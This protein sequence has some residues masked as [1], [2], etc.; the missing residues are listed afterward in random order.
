MSVSKRAG[1][2]VYHYDFQVNGVRFQGST[3]AN[4]RREAEKVEAG[5]KKQVRADMESALASRT[6]PSLSEVFA[7]YWLAH[8][9]DLRSARDVERALTRALE[10]LGGKRLFSEIGTEEIS[11]IL[12]AYAQTGVTNRSVMY[13]RDVLRSVWRRAEQTWELHT[14]PINWKALGRK[15]QNT[16]Y[17]FL[18]PE[19][20]ADVISRLPRHIQQMVEWSLL[21]GCRLNETETLVWDQVHEDQRTAYVEAKGGGLTPVELNDE[22]LVL[23]AEIGRKPDGT[24]VFNSTNRRKHWEAAVSAAGI[25][26]FHWHDLRHTHATWLGQSGASLAVIKEAL[27]HSTIQSTMRYA[28]TTR[29]QVKSAVEKLPKVKM[30]NR[31]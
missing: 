1:R 8:G 5:I 12:E 26:D 16:R 21:T 30:Q 2:E 9:K 23:L 7:R 24:P 20:A 25:E 29:Q 13:Y 17:R 3:G 15:V 31:D 11:A 18:T 6:S 27:R 19:Q 4:S 14:K 10:A 22:A 28:H